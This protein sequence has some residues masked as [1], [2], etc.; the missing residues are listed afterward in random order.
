MKWGMNLDF[1]SYISD[2]MNNLLRVIMSI[3]VFDVIDIL[4]LAVLICVV[5]K[6]MQDTR[7]E[8]L[9]KGILI[10]VV[11]FL[12]VQACQ[13]KVMSFLF[14]NFFQVGLLAV[15][16]VFQPELRRMLEKVGTAKVPNIV[17]SFDT[18]E[19][20]A[21]QARERAI[22]GIADACERLSRTRTGALIVIER[23]TKL[24]NIIEQSTVINSEPSP[25]LFCNLFYNKAPLHDGAVIIRNNRIYAAGCFLPI[26]NKGQYVDADL[27]SRHRAALGMSENSDALVIVVSEETGII[28]VAKAGQLTRFDTEYNPK[29]A[30]INIL[31]DEMPDVIKNKTR[32]RTRRT[33]TDG[34]QED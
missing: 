33:R 18:G 13:L 23:Q 21:A 7:A 15:V 20:G 9:L 19:A 26:T 25:E 22:Q 5:I 16:I 10:L 17:Q 4:L 12:V 29:E 27:G 6:F 34:A 30:L 8:Q 2:I 32:R 14:Q 1:L 28:S 3:T 31:R 11:L 24:G